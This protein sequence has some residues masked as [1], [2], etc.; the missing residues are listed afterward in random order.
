M[1]RMYV[2]EGEGVDNGNI[3]INGS[4]NCDPLY[5][6]RACLWREINKKWNK[7]N[8]GVDCFSPYSQKVHI[9]SHDKH[10]ENTQQ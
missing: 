7:N 3:D 5:I 4:V 6:V 8:L 2:L 1:W 10:S 9:D